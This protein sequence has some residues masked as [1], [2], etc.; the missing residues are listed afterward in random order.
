MIAKFLLK[1]LAFRCESVNYSFKRWE[2]LFEL[3]I[4]SELWNLALRI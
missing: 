2:M 4:R 3:L 1:V